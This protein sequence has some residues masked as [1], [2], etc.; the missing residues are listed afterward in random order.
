MIETE[1]GL[2]PEGAGWFVVNVRDACWWKH[3]TFGLAVG[4][5]GN[6]TERRRKSNTSD[7]RFEQLGINIQV[8]EPGQPNC[9]YHAEGAQEDFL[10]L[11]GECLLLVEG[12]ERRLRAWDFVHCPP[13]TEH[14][15]VGAGDGPC[16]ILMI[17]ARR[18]PEEVLYP[19]SE[20]A[21]RHGA[22]VSVEASDPR[23]AYAPYTKS[24]RAR[25]QPRGLPWEQP[26]G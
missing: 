24:R 18:E 15:F 7:A 22:G 10:V 14:V 13:F 2:E 5:E 25:P 21:R 23:V 3:D 6:E 17:G 8:L 4:F 26:R 11:A 1:G 16:A 12:Q 20:L 19:V 9:M